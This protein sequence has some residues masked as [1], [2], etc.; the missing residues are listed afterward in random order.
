VT[1]KPRPPLRSGGGGRAQRGRRGAAEDPLQVFAVPHRQVRAAEADRGRGLGKAERDADVEQRV[2]DDLPEC[3]RVPR[4]AING[5]GQLDLAAISGNQAV[6]GVEDLW[7]KHVSPDEPERRRRLLASGLFDGS[8]H[9][10]QRLPFPAADLDHAIPI[11]QLTFD[12]ADREHCT[13]IEGR[14]ERGRESVHRVREHVVREQAHERP[15]A[16]H[17]RRSENRIAQPPGMILR[18]RGYRDPLEAFDRTTIGEVTEDRIARPFVDHEHHLGHS[19]GRRLF[20]HVLDDRAINDSDHRLRDHPCGGE[21]SGPRPGTRDDRDVDLHAGIMPDSC[22][23]HA[24][25]RLIPDATEG[26][27]SPPSA[28]IRIRASA[29]WEPASSRPASWP[30]SWQASWQ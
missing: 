10:H 17:V 2:V 7:R 24:D 14:D 3:P 4:Q 13:A 26:G 23:P 29:S 9:R 19:A 11:E 27:V 16:D 21:H 12:L 30:A 28:P 15:A 6:Q 18:H 1:P 25:T 20:D 5:I 22:R 8:R